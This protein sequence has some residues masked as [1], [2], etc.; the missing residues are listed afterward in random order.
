MIID[1]IQI[2]DDI[3]FRTDIDLKQ[4]LVLNSEHIRYEEESAQSLIKNRR[5]LLPDTESNC[6]K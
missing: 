5:R 2:Y 4:K 1:L 6:F 3:Y